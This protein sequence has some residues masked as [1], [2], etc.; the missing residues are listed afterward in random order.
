MIDRE[1]LYLLSKATKGLS[2]F[3]ALSI[4]ILPSI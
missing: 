1:F 3:V 4:K 2:P